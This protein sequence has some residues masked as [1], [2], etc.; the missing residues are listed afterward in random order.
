M[1]QTSDQA[2]CVMEL[3]PLEFNEFELALTLRLMSPSSDELKNLIEESGSITTP[4]IPAPRRAMRAPN[5]TSSDKPVASPVF[6]SIPVSAAS[7]TPL[8][9]SSQ[10]HYH[11][12]TPSISPLPLVPTTPQA[13][14]SSHLIP[15]VNVQ[16][17]ISVDATPRSAPL[18][19]LP[20]P[21]IAGDGAGGDARGD[22]TVTHDD[23]GM[24]VVAPG[25]GLISASGSAMSIQNLADL[26]REAGRNGITYTPWVPPGLTIDQIKENRAV[27]L[28][29]ADRLGMAF[30]RAFQ[31]L[32]LHN[33]D[34][35]YEFYT[36]FGSELADLYSEPQVVFHRA[37]PPSDTQ[38]TFTTNAN[39]NGNIPNPETVNN[40]H[41]PTIPPPEAKFSSP[42]HAPLGP[43]GVSAAPDPTTMTPTGLLN[44]PP[45]GASQP[46]NAPVAGPSSARTGSIPSQFDFGAMAGPSNSRKRLASA[47]PVDPNPTAK[48]A[49]A[50]PSPILSAPIVISAPSSPLP[51]SNVA[52]A[53]L[54]A[55]QNIPEP[56]VAAPA[57]PKS[58]AKFTAAQKGKGR[59]MPTVEEE[60]E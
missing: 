8:A 30:C 56:V 1:L 19:G 38:A 41:P 53:P 42:L 9:G 25:D 23:S 22:D 18:S 54:G 48:K 58:P 37:A 26:E 21:A 13:S 15:V 50:P 49:S 36:G 4:A 46:L 28:H 52:P 51:S 31:R 12:T 39:E 40:T 34:A 20:V 55:T 17:H 45:A 47:V 44:A 35:W 14:G 60:P 3:S 57:P 33:S 5:P 7:T 2:N 29:Q 10:H 27:A 11:H 16:D 32:A 24:D 43:T 59:A 6:T